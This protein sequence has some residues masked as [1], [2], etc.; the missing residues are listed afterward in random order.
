MKK[1]DFKEFKPEFYESCEEI[2]E[3]NG[4][5]HR[6]IVFP[7]CNRCPF[8]KPI[9]HHTIY[10]DN[11]VNS[12]K[13]YIKLYETEYMLYILLT[14]L[15]KENEMEI[16]KTKFGMEKEIKELQKTLITNINEQLDNE[17]PMWEKYTNYLEVLNHLL[18]T[19]NDYLLNKK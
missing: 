16:I 18:K 4:C 11:K 19:V 5:T 6:G 7:E 14:K 10:C 8:S 9:V 13:T 1:S 3:Q 12:S 15:E 17:K 2:I